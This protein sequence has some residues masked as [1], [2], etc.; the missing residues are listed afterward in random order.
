MTVKA[1]MLASIIK[2]IGHTVDY[3]FTTSKDGMLCVIYVYEHGYDKDKDRLD[4]I[5]AEYD[6]CMES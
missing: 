1:S 5:K 3:V 6:K 2:D 4:A